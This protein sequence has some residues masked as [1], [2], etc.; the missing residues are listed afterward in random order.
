M[1]IYAILHYSN[2]KWWK[3]VI[4]NTEYIILGVLIDLGDNRMI[5]YD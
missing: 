4:V 1:A 2:Q 5:M 3:R